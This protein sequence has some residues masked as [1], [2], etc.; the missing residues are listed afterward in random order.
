[1]WYL[2]VWYSWGFRSA[3]FLG[4]DSCHTATKISEPI[5]WKC[6]TL[7]R[8]LETCSSSNTRLL[9][10]P[11][12]TLLDFCYDAIFPTDRQKKL[13]S[14][15]TLSLICPGNTWPRVLKT[16]TNGHQCFRFQ[17][18]FLYYSVYLSCPCWYTALYIRLTT[19]VT[20]STQIQPL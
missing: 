20:A 1:M 10:F 3:G 11:S 19:N 18:N 14:W 5:C 2:H 17:C 16:I 8:S 12:G 9:K 15:H 7:K 6:K 4:D 13:I